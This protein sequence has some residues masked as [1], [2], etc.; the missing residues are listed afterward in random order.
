[1]ANKEPNVQMFPYN[2]FPSK[3]CKVG[4]LQK[5]LRLSEKNRYYFLNISIKRKSIN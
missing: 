2:I 1:M 3:E 4:I 5:K